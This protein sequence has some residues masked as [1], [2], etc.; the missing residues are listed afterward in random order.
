[1]AELE[2]DFRPKILAEIERQR[3][4][5][6][7]YPLDIPN[8]VCKHAY[9]KGILVENSFN[10]TTGDYS[11][12]CQI[13]DES[14]YVWTHKSNIYSALV[15]ETNLDVKLKPCWKTA[16]NLISLS[17]AFYT[18]FEGA[19]AEDLPEYK[20]MYYFDPNNS[21]LDN[22]VFYG[23][24]ALESHF[25]SSGTV[26]KLTEIASFAPLLELLLRDDKAYTALSMVFSAFCI[27]KCCLICELSDHPWHDHLAEEPKIWKQA[28]MIP[29]LEIA[30]V[31]SCRA[32]E[33][34]LGEPPNRER[35]R[36]LYEHKQHW[37]KTIGIN[38][39]DIF[40]K[41]EKTF[42]DFYYELFDKLRN[43]SAHS[44][45]NIHYD[46]ERKSAVEAQCFAAIIVREYVRK[47]II[48][49]ASA[50]DALKFDK[51]LL[52][53]VSDTMSTCLTNE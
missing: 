1:M 50:I 41:A 33:A 4:L 11:F 10:P 16:V 38:P 31:Q 25:L 53:R 28:E 44:F 47:N 23:V 45:G 3:M 32:A 7:K 42:L 35:P 43:P 24:S 13:G 48:D 6:E 8:E 12:L 19:S 39:D 30:V 27:H 18:S 20:W 14:I 29:N 5:E 22:I 2:E 46:L 15:S 34:I 51:T 36:K 26:F 52:G 9:I 37:I 49:E 21:T 40:K 17:K